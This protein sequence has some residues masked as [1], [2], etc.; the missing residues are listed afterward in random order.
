MFDHQ[1]NAAHRVVANYEHG[2]TMADV[3]GRG[4]AL[5]SQPDGFHGTF[6]ILKSPSR[7]FGAR[8]D[9]GGRPR[10]RV[11]RGEVRAQRP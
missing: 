7:R 2:Q 9:P 6:R 1:L 5:R 3:I 8:A 10:W 4:V 11:V